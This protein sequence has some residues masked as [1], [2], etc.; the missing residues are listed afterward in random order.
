MSKNP[1]TSPT[2]SLDSARAAYSHW[3]TAVEADLQGA[4]FDKKLVTRTFEGVSL[5]PLYT[6]A[7]ATGL[8]H[9]AAQPGTAPRVFKFWLHSRNLGNFSGNWRC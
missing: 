2:Q 8:T 9:A 4:S 3:R 6:R 7:D 5:Q 1:E